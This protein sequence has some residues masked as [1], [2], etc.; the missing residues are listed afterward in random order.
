MV[1]AWWSGAPPR[2]LDIGG[3][4]RTPPAVPP[5]VTVRRVAPEQPLD[6]VAVSRF[7]FDYY[8]TSS[9][10]RCVVPFTHIHEQLVCGYWELY[11]A[12]G[13]GGELVGTVVRRLLK[14]LQIG[15]AK[16]SDGGGVID[17]FCVRPGWRGKGVGRL[18]LTL[19]HNSCPVPM[20]PQLILW[21]GIQVKIPPFA[22]GAFWSC[23]APAT[24]P[25]APM[26]WFKSQ[27]SL[28]TLC[29][30]IA[31]PLVSANGG[32]AETHAYSSP[33]GHVVLWD[34][35][36]KSVPEGRRVA[37]VVAYSSPEAVDS[38][39]Q[40]GAAASGFG[41]FLATSALSDRWEFDSP[42]CWVAYNCV[43]GKLGLGAFPAL[44][45]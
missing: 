19:V 3:R 25:A 6:M 43:F 4:P 17:Y 21:E 30:R 37:I 1:S 5:G 32:C 22:A 28:L 34:T 44:G 26:T 45:L 36:H 15:S 2:L 31:A 38:F 41:I 24:A 7:W 16:W 33:A 29:K 14:D 35:F 20:P 39:V 10:T 42:Y 23:S 13:P 8:A 18:L 11:A 12:F 9:R 27:E 40:E